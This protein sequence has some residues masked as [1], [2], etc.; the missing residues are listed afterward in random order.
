MNMSLELMTGI[1]QW[2]IDYIMQY[3]ISECSCIEQASM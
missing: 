1:A 3:N 2:Y